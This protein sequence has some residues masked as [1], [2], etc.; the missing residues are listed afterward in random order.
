MGA[1]K[2]KEAQMARTPPGRR[3]PHRRTR[4]PTDRTEKIHFQAESE[5]GTP[6]PGKTGP[7]PSFIAPSCPA[8]VD[9]YTLTF[10][11]TASDG[12]NISKTERVVVTVVADGR[13]ARGLPRH[14]RIDRIRHDLAT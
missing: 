13:Y 11:V 7:M 14:A 1:G 4:R 6:D 12:A 2:A 3:G 8:G 10:D 5:G 9:S